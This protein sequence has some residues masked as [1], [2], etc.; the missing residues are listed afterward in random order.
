M[1]LGRLAPFAALLVAAATSASCGTASSSTAPA[2]SPSSEH[3]Y[4]IVFVNDT[5]QPIVIVGCPECGDGHRIADRGRWGTGVDGG[6]T[7]VR[8]YSGDRRRLVG[9]IHMNNGA[10]PAGGAS[11]QTIDISYGIPCRG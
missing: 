6:L 7:E 9:C 8:F 4:P 5:G 10:M 3:A 2:T 1:G 11:A